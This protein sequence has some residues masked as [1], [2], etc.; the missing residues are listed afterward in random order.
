MP[1]NMKILTLART[2]RNKVS[3]SEKT[4][5]DSRSRPSIQ[6]ED[7][8]TGR[9]E[10]EALATSVEKEELVEQMKALELARSEQGGAQ[11]D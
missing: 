1:T 7:V 4:I 2:R 3:G 11:E 6:E 5:C 10:D 9:K 8:T